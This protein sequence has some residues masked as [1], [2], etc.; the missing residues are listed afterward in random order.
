M[1][2]QENELEN[3]IKKEIT[4]QVEINSSQFTML[5]KGGMHFFVI[6]ADSIGE[7]D[8]DGDFTPYR[9]NLRVEFRMPNESM[10]MHTSTINK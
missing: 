4:V 1:R 8:E 3:K 7:Y 6:D 2:T 10:Y 9:G 5:S